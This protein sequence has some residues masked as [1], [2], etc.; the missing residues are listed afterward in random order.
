MKK[1][2]I[3]NKLTGE[4]TNANQGDD[5]AV[6][7]WLEHHVNYGSFG[8]GAWTETVKYAVQDEQGNILEPAEYVEH[9]AEYEIIIEDKTAEVEA[10]KIKKE[11]KQKDRESRVTELKKIAW[12]DINTVQELK[13]VVK[14]IH[15]ELLKDEE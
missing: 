1:I 15:E 8:R 3:K 10:E 14:F 12:K 13:Q 5:A 11:K 9:E 6:M 4:I 2:S 7:A